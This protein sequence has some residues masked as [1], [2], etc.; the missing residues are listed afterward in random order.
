MRGVFRSGPD[1]GDEAGRRGRGSSAEFKCPRCGA[2]DAC[3][4][5]V[6]TYTRRTA[7]GRPR[8]VRSRPLCI[9]CFIQLTDPRDGEAHDDGLEVV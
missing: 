1:W 6:R 2:W 5:F 8:K 4:A 3:E 9:G 7:F